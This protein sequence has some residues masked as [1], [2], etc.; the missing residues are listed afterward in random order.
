LPT[1]GNLGLEAG[2]NRGSAHVGAGARFELIS[3]HR[4]NQTRAVSQDGRA[5]RRYKQLRKIHRLFP[6]LQRFHRILK[7]NGYRAANL[8]GLVQLGCLAILMVI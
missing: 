7:R 5:L 2:R 4:A 8:L 6:W 1:G 3:P